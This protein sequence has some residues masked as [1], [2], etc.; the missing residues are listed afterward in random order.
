MRTWFL[1]ALALL[2]LLP[3]AIGAG[4]RIAVADVEKIFRE[5]YKSKIAEDV[6]R[7]QSEVYR[8]YLLKLKDEL[9]KLEDAHA[10]A[11]DGAQN[12]ALSDAE[13]AEFEVSARRKG[14]EIAIKRAEAEKYAVD[15]NKQMI[16]LELDK[17]AEVLDDIRAE[18]KRRAAAEGYDFVLD[19]S[20]RTSNDISMVVY[21]NP[22]ADLTAE[23][24]KSLNA[25]AVGVNEKK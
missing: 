22:T 4:Q 23:L 5:Y 9:K 20:G 7:Q 10:V 6:I 8:A 13:R 17:R 24:I 11:R 19:V 18:V 14:E 2:W 15:K 1:G 16:K 12:I 3:A 25:T 21:F